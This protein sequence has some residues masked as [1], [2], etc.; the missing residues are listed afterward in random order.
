MKVLFA[1]T[2]V[3]LFFAFCQQA[4][5]DKTTNSPE[6]YEDQKRESS[7]N[8]TYIVAGS[9]IAVTAIIGGV[10]ISIKQNNKNKD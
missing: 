6:F 8:T 10:A 1:A 9:L 5:G 2:F 7:M 4:R 3:L